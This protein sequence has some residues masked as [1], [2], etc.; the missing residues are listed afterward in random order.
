MASKKVFYIKNDQI[1]FD[2]IDFKYYNGFSIQQKQKSILSMHEEINN[3]YDGDILE[4]SSKSNNE[5]GRKLSAFNLPVEINGIKTKLE[6]L[7]QSSKVF[8]N[9]GPYRD[10]L[11]CSPV[12][13][14]KDERLVNSG[15]LIKFTLN[16]K[17]YSIEPK[18]SFY[19]YIY[20][21]S[22]FHQKDLINDLLKYTIFTDIE[23]NHLKSI[24]CQ[25]QSAAIFVLLYKKGIIKQ[26]LTDFEWFKSYVYKELITE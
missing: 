13:A 26:A 8:S 9:G 1:F 18:T 20:C 15:N 22:L 12:K 16:N 19:D 7:F 23:F 10:L 6:N 4:I 24:N 11:L 2:I 3:K 5:L 21:V 25:A 14:K 17:D